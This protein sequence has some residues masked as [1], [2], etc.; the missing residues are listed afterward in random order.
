ML[1]S[2]ELNAASNFISDEVE[3]FS[4]AEVNTDKE[5]N[6]FEEEKFIQFP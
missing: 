6:D 3:S 1:K 2:V 4:D 5:D